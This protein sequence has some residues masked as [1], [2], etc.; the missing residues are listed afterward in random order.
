MAIALEIVNFSHE[1]NTI[2]TTSQSSIFIATVTSTGT[3]MQVNIG[4]SWKAISAMQI[5]IG[6][7]WKTVAAAKI[8]IGDSWKA[9][10]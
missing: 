8:N 9:I 5:N 10:F 6:D 4:D 2:A 3:K 7:A 1:D